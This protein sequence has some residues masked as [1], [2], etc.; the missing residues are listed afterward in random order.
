MRRFESIEAW[1]HISGGILLLTFCVSHVGFVLLPDLYHPLENTVF[2]FLTNRMVYGVAAFFELTIAVICL[3]FQ[4]RSVANIAILTFVA[5][6][7]WYRWALQLT[8][9]GNSCDCLGLLARLLH[10]TKTAEETIPILVLIVL[11]LI[12]LPWLLRTMCKY[13]RKPVRVGILLLALFGHTCIAGEMAI[14]LHGEYDRY[15]FNLKTAG[16]LAFSADEIRDL[17]QFTSKLVQQSDPISAFLWQSLPSQGQMTLANYLSSKTSSGE[18]EDILVGAIK[19][20]L[21]GPSIYTHERF[22]GVVLQAETT[23]LMGQNPSG[24]NLTRLNHLLLDDAYPELLLG[25]ATMQPLPGTE[26][27]RE[28]RT[29]ISGDQWRISATNMTAKAKGRNY[30]AEVVYDG[31]NTYTMSPYSSSFTSIPLASDLVFATESPSPFLLSAV[32]SGVGT[33]LPW[34]TYGLSPRLVAPAKNGVVAIP[35]PWSLPR[36][37]G[38]GFGF[39]WVI[40][41]SSD[42]RFME[43]CRIIRDVSLDLDDKTELCLRPEVDYPDTVAEKDHDLV[44]LR[45][46][47]SLANGYV[48]TEYKCTSWYQ[49][50]GFTIPIRS[51]MIQNILGHP[52]GRETLVVTG[53]SVVDRTNEVL[54][55]PAVPTVMHDYRYK[56]AN[57]KRIFRYAN[58]TLMP[59]ENWKSDS[60]P[61]LLASAA[62]FLKSGPRYD[63]VWGK[64]N[65]FAWLVLLLILLG[66]A[67]AA[68]KMANKG[69]KE[70]G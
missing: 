61:L 10:V 54:G 49:T 32:S 25:S 40:K 12:T 17:S 5:S 51:E 31:T 57:E 36:R 27:H 59:G 55:L 8:G 35:L 1:L 16:T 2:P 14:E 23:N 65:I 38:Y 19:A 39:R 63:A 68:L 4:G 45:L 37:P 20:I 46:R 66:P 33:S 60:D 64:T 58:Y 56:R 3:K 42:G 26:E 67:C 13:M 47:K 28:F 7:L 53:I 70:K 15:N 21:E 62:E 18:C 34:L 48:D 6:M 50:N 22:K 69:K 41:A 24:T 43:S 9:G 11:T 52:F 30:W 44:N 29:L